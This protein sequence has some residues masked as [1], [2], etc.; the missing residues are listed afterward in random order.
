V[1]LVLMYQVLMQ[2]YA[3]KKNPVQGGSSGTV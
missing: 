3:K 2:R 1:Y